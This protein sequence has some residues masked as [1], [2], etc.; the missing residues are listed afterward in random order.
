MWIPRSR[1]RINKSRY[2]NNRSRYHIN[3]SRYG[4]SKSSTSDLILA[5]QFSLDMKQTNLSKNIPLFGRTSPYF[6]S[7]QPKHL[8]LLRD[9]FVKVTWSSHPT[10]QSVCDL[11][12]CWSEFDGLFELFQTIQSRNIVNVC[13]LDLNI[14]ANFSAARSHNLNGSC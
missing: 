10:L 5:T 3:K 12:T 6:L 14:S 2:S 4:I 7:I 13:Y 11:I 9:V 8:V 1:Y